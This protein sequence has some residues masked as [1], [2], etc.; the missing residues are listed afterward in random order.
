MPTKQLTAGD[1]TAT[2]QYG[3]GALNTIQ[4]AATRAIPA[5]AMERM[6]KAKP[7]ASSKYGGF[8]GEG[9]EGASGVG[10]GA[11]EPD[12]T[13]FVGSLSGDQLV[14]LISGQSE[15]NR[16]VIETVLVQVSEGAE[17]KWSKAG[18]VKLS[19]FVDQELE[20]ALGLAIIEHM[21]GALAEYQ[22]VMRPNSGTEA[23]TPLMPPSTPT[24][25]AISEAVG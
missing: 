25:S 11:A 4:S 19:E 15:Q 1:Q 2:I 9:S 14:A 24:P 21:A 13:E 12:P 17:V 23:P 3:W 22:A 10:G 8:G 5:E 6:L 18:G 20:P 7:M 16:A